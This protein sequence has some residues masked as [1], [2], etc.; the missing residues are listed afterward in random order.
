MGIFGIK[1]VFCPKNEWTT[2]ISSYFAQMPVSWQIKF[3]SEN[4]EAID[5]IYSEKRFFWFFPQPPTEGKL[6]AEMI[7]DRYWINTFYSIK[8]CPTVDLTAEI[9]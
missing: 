6:V 7:F 1:K 8:I 3:V 4:G 5:R 2:I 9:D